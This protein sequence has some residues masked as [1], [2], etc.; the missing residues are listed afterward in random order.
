MR[1]TLLQ[2]PWAYVLTDHLPGKATQHAWQL[3]YNSWVDG[4]S[5]SAFMGKCARKGSTLVLAKDKGGA[6]F[7]GFA[8]EPWRKQGYF[9][10]NESSF[11]FSVMPAFRV[12]HCQA[13]NGNILWCGQGFSELP[14]GL[15]FG[16]RHGYFGL[17]LDGHFEGGESRRVANFGNE[18]LSGTPR[19]LID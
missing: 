8:S 18:Q 12:F 1:H 9:F 5:F 15:A 3:L 13:V 7:G 6:V 4:L 17:Y 14:N 16:G 10:G 2:P 19:F 11:I